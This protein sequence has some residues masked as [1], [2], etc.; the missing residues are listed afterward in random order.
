MQGGDCPPSGSGSSTG[1]GRAGSKVCKARTRAHPHTRAHAHMHILW[2]TRPGTSAGT[3]LG[4]SCR[5]L[6]APPRPSSASAQA[7]QTLPTGGTA[8]PCTRPGAGDNVLL[9]RPPR[10]PGWAPGPRLHGK[11]K[12]ELALAQP[13][14]LLC[15]SPLPQ[16]STL[17]TLLQTPARPRVLTC[18]PFMQL[19]TPANTWPKAPSPG[20]LSGQRP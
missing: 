1:K 10:A 3:C 7:P 2:P 20:G 5:R 11:C 19:H 17:L 18:P 9:P 16:C 6:H 14:L 4:S 8:G 15:P 13:S 12:S